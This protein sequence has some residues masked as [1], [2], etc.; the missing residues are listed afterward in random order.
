MKASIRASSVAVTV[1]LR[2][3]K[4]SSSQ[5]TCGSIAGSSGRSSL[6]QRRPISV[7]VQNSGKHALAVCHGHR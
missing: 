1:H 3:L 2:R 5:S 4:S 6:R 7:C